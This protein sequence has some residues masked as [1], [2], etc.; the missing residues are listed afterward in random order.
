VPYTIYQIGRAYILVASTTLERLLEQALLSKM[1]KLSN[2]LYSD[3][4]AG[5]Q[6][7]IEIIPIG[8]C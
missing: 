2:T 3:L 8:R 7:G 1:R 5:W 4:F 6:L